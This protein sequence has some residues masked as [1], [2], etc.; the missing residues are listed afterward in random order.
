[1][2]DNRYSEIQK[3]F[4]LNLFA[5]GASNLLLED[6]TALAKTLGSMVTQAFTDCK[7]DLGEWEIVWGPAVFSVNEFKKEQP[8]AYGEMLQSLNTVGQFVVKS[9]VALLEDTGKS[10]V[11]NAMYVA[12]CAETQSYVVALS[13][14]NGISAFDWAAEDFFVGGKRSWSDVT[15]ISTGRG[16]ISAGTAI[17]LD[18][19]RTMASNGQTLEEFFEAIVDDANGNVNIT[20][21]G[22]SLGGALAPALALALEDLRESWDPNG[23]AI[24][25]VLP[26][27]G[28]T[29]GD[30]RFSVYYESKLGMRTNR[31][32][33]TLDVI[34]HA[35]DRNQILHVP[36]IYYPY[37]IAGAPA[38]LLTLLALV[39]SVEGGTYRHINPH[40]AGLPGQVMLHKEVLFELSPLEP[41]GHDS[42]RI[43]FIL[44][45]HILF[46]FFSI[47][48][49]TVERLEEASR[50]LADLIWNPEDASSMPHERKA[51]AADAVHRIKRDIAFCGNPYGQKIFKL[52][53]EIL[54]DVDNVRNFFAQMGYQHVEAYFQ[55]M[56]VDAI[57][58]YYE[59]L[60]RARGIEAAT[61]ESGS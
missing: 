9:Q 27:A 61:G 30:A 14:T 45:L 60:A 33:N 25:N 34:A 54:E 39:D 24:I 5:N 52:L 22:H 12:Y 47:S 46:A 43:I 28:P 53:E 57:M 41:L 49:V 37:Q 44:L 17:G 18:I 48:R 21:T 2:A 19:L 15:G 4:C 36:D 6:S 8:G 50:A 26:S 59:L 40:T 16:C 7:S 35:W 10:L 42:I 38:Y 29:P 3:V 32:W 20:V 55:L 23:K 51:A 1:M 56:G 13:G 31:I 58:R 11:D